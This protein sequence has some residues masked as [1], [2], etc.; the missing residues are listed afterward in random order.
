MPG[1]IKKALLRY[2]HER[3]ARIQYSP[4]PAAPR[5]F[6][7]TAQDPFPDDD[8]PEATKEEV[9]YIQQVVGTIL[10]Y[11]RA[12]DLTVLMALSTIASEQAKATKKTIKNVGQMLDYLAWSPTQQ[13]DLLHQT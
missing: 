13:S 2:K 4:Y 6:G 9:T 12:V 1:Y 8:E 5:T 11:A 7:A 10:Y 3:S